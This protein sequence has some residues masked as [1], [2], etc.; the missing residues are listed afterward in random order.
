MFEIC[1]SPIDKKPLSEDECNQRVKQFTMLNRVC[2]ITNATTFLEKVIHFDPFNTQTTCFLVGM[3]TI[4]RI[5]DP[6]YY[7]N[8]QDERDRC[9]KLIK[10]RSGRFI[11]FPRAG[12]ENHIPSKEMSE[13][14]E[15][16][17]DFTPVDISSTTIRN[18][19][20]RESCTLNM[21]KTGD[22]FYYNNSSYK[23]IYC[24]PEQVIVYNGEE[25]FPMNDKIVVEK[26]NHNFWPS[27]IG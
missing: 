16:V 21:L 15:F 10:G 19:D 6:A 12:I 18:D 11:V 13:L 2:Y 17:K 26:T 3:D 9:L 25:F 4:S 27:I 14:V 24:N 1:R 22:C 7:L 5:D 20:K 8:S 23:V